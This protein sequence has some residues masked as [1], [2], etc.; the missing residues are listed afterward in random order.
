[1]SVKRESLIGEW[2]WS[3]V[4]SVRRRQKMN[5]PPSPPP[6]KDAVSSQSPISVVYDVGS[7]HLF[8]KG[9]V[10]F[11]SSHSHRRGT[12]V[13]FHGGST[14]EWVWLHHTNLWAFSHYTA[15]PWG[16]RKALSSL[17][18]RSD[19]SL[20]PWEQQG[21]MNSRAPGIT[22]GFTRVNSI[23][24]RNKRAVGETFVGREQCARGMP[25]RVSLM[26]FNGNIT[27]AIRGK[28]FLN[29]YVPSVPYGRIWYF[30]SW[31]CSVWQKWQ[32][33]QSCTSLSRCP[34]FVHIMLWANVWV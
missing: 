6:K 33:N 7:K 18:Q 34:P 9:R 20:A 25:C 17:A 10:F 23:L 26:H 15:Q 2:L 16:Q 5:P 12:P 1:M 4:V 27:H 32:E 8:T 3:E 21:I 13:G 24:E 22:F 19:F 31:S 29:T 14:T 11:R 30:C 28:L